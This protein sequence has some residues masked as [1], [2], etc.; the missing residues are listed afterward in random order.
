MIDQVWHANTEIMGAVE[1]VAFKR[2]M[3]GMVSLGMSNKSV[4]EWAK[5]WEKNRPSW[6]IEAAE[7]F[8]RVTSSLGIAASGAHPEEMLTTEQAEFYIKVLAKLTPDY[9]VLLKC[10]LEILRNALI[11]VIVRGD[12]S[13]RVRLLPESIKGRIFTVSPDIAPKVSSIFEKSGIISVSIGDAGKSASKLSKSDKSLR[14]AVKGLKG[15]RY[16]LFIMDRNYHHTRRLQDVIDGSLCLFVSS[17]ELTPSHSG[18]YQVQMHAIPQESVMQSMVECLESNIRELGRTEWI[19]RSKA[20]K[21]MWG[22]EKRWRTREQVAGTLKDVFY[23]KTTSLGVTESSDG[24]LFRE[25][26]GQIQ[27]RLN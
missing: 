24:L 16:V 14:Q 9:G 7:N 15:L 3:C 10:E 6:P 22:K 2:W 11:F 26:K 12:R 18:I 20:I 5:V 21:S 13:K 17:D 25:D 27:V 1:R 23:T 19:S 4:K 8:A